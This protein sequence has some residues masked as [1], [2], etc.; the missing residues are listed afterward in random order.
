MGTGKPQKNFLSNIF[1]KKIIPDNNFP[2]YGISKISDSDFL[3][4]NGWLSLIM[5]SLATQAN[6]YVSAVIES[7]LFTIKRIFSY[8][9]TL[10]IPM[11]HRFSQPHL[12]S[13]EY[14]IR[15]AHR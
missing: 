13:H 9:H 11:Y 2:D 7:E 4:P 14:Y 15:A 1:S 6:N 5:P 3:D 10:A 8:R 12:L